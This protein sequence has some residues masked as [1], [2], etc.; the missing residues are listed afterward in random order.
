MMSIGMNEL[1]EFDPSQA[2]GH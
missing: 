2:L 1:W